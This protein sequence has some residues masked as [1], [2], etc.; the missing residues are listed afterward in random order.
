MAQVNNA[1]G[2]YNTLGVNTNL[3]GDSLK[4]YSPEVQKQMNSLPPV[5]SSWQ[6]QD[7]ANN[8]V[9]GYTQN[10]VLSSIQSISDAANN[11]LAYS[12]II[13]STNQ[14]QITALIGGMYANCQYL[15]I[16]NEAVETQNAKTFLY[17]TNRL[18]GIRVAQ[19]DSTEHID[20]TNLPYYS[21]A[22]QAAK[23]ASYIVNQTDGVNDNSVM[24]SCFTSILAAN[25]FIQL[26]NTISGSANT[27]IQSLSYIPAGEGA[28][29]GY[30]TSNVSLQVATQLSRA[31][32]NTVNLMQTR[33]TADVTF[34]VNLKNF[35]SNFNSTK[36]FTNM[37]D[38]E[39]LLVNNF[40]GTNKLKGNLGVPIGGGG[41]SGGS[42]NSSG[43]ITS[44]Q[45]IV[46]QYG[47][48]TSGL[49]PDGTV[50]DGLGNFQLQITGGVPNS[51][52][53]YSTD[54]YAK[55]NTLINDSNLADYGFADSL[56]T[57]SGVLWTGIISG[58]LNTEDDPHS[59]QG[60]P[61]SA[62]GL[63]IAK[64][65]L[66][67][68][69]PTS[70]LHGVGYNPAYDPFANVKPDG[71]PGIYEGKL[72]SKGSSIV[73]FGH[74]GSNSITLKN[75][76]TFVITFENGHKQTANVKT[77]YIGGTIGTGTTSVASVPPG[78]S[79]SVSATFPVD[80]SGID[81]TVSWFVN[82]Y[83][84]NAFVQYYPGGTITIPAG[85]SSFT[86]TGAGA[87]AYNLSSG[88]QV[89]I[90]LRQ[91]GAVGSIIGGVSYTV[92]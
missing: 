13:G 36:Q 12:P 63:A 45:E 60:S 52:F 34:Y 17:H 31:F 38:T 26:A 6:A 87:G 88:G 11:V 29:N 80:P 81:S 5:I 75:E 57:T 35:T 55:S 73:Q 64:N 65:Y 8:S 4:T 89:S 59:V 19:D 69:L 72:D 50:A 30:Y 33:E 49:L 56:R 90:I 78:S 39:K 23:T 3:L 44:N 25:Q 37:G 76:G 83:Q 15:S 7:I 71:I 2:V 92:T 84:G 48:G 74:L 61:L 32:G 42:A 9:G 77:A 58:Q 62:K 18:S 16:G 28:G 68:S 10:P 43:T 82:T 91:S 51:T 27:F 85:S 20:S 86:I 14:N 53:L 54:N 41:G 66:G 1:T 47:L 79:T 70:R 22:V 46:K 67:L 21:V 24:L 40:I